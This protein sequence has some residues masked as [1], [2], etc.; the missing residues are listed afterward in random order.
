MMNYHQFGIGTGNV[1]FPRLT[2]KEFSANACFIDETP[3]L[4]LTTLLLQE[5]EHFVKDVRLQSTPPISAVKLI[6]RTRGGTQSSIVQCD[7][8]R[9]YLMKLNGSPQGPN[10]LANEVLG[11]RLGRA[12]GLPVAETSLLHV[13][14]AFLDENPSLYFVNKTTRYR[15][16][17]GVHLGCS[18]VGEFEGADRTLEWIGLSDVRSI[19][20]RQDF[21]GMYLFDVWAMHQDQRQA[22]FVRNPITRA[23]RGTFVDNGHLCGGPEWKPHSGRSEACHREKSI[24]TGLWKH[25]AVQGWTRIFQRVIPRELSGISE[26]IPRHWYSGD[27]ESL[28]ASLSSRLNHLPSIFEQSSLLEPRECTD[29]RTQ[30]SLKQRL[31]NG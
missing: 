20:N 8:G 30:L 10:V 29:V 31:A 12:V 21:L 19:D 3:Q 5:E 18:L 25:K 11:S 22:L 23:L 15:P 7:D 17:P 14:R 13:T 26:H 1:L 28:C 9:Y 24:Y 4:V 16:D 6:R 27:L 2:C